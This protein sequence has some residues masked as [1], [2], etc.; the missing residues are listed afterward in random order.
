MKIL[1]VGYLLGQ[2][3][4]QTHLKWL[5]KMLGEEGVETL[6]LSL[7]SRNVSSE[8]RKYLHSLQSDRV[9]FI[10]CSSQKG[11]GFNSTFSEI[12]RLAEIIGIIRRFSPDIYLAAGVGWNL[13]I[14]PL[15]AGHKARC[16]F[17]E[18]MSGEPAGWRDSRW[19]VRAWFDEV[20]GQSPTVAKTFA[21]CFGWRK[22]IPALAA[23]PEP[24]E[25][26]ANLPQ[27]E[28]RVV[29]LGKARAALFSRLV[30]HKQAYWLVQQWHLL[31]DV[32]GELHIHGSGPEEPLIREYISQRGLGDRVKC[33]GRYPE[34]QAYVD[35]LGNYD[36]TLLP[37]IGA[38]GAPLV[39]LES[40]AC[41]VPFVA[42][43]VGGI[44]D[45][46]VNN[47]NV[48]VVTPEPWVTAQ[49]RN[50]PT[51]EDKDLEN[52]VNQEPSA[53]I[54]A[55]REMALKLADRQVN[56]AQ[57]QQFYLEHYSYSALKK[58]WLTYLGN[59]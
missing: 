48:S 36:L 1:L 33:F 45:Y 25:I 17:H 27:P 41:G 42:Y 21:T 24:L 13:F 52:S 34:G 44:P 32:L 16:I 46:G 59:K 54:A 37:T 39:L 57:L 7:G 20:V 15:L 9:R 3:G 58:V 4:I 53:F 28:T 56:Q 6:A 18:V 38:E 23:I 10:C 47:P 51:V 50:P 40:M 11:Q 30:P 22:L 26:T 31:E 5:A 19:G 29:E 14:P 2:G 8:D 35:L 12:Q 43:G 55:V 49:P